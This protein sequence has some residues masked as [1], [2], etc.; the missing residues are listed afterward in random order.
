MN[1]KTPVS[2]I[3]TLNSLINEAHGCAVP[4]TR[5]HFIDQQDSC[6]RY[7]VT[8]AD[9]EVTI[10]VPLPRFS[11]I[12]HLD[13]L[14]E[15]FTPEM[16]FER[17]EAYITNYQ[18]RPTEAISYALATF[19]SQ[20]ALVRTYLEGRFGPLLSKA[21]KLGVAWWAESIDV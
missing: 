8:L 14:H 13:R 11:V 6:Y 21:R 10:T 5:S 2:R 3:K 7:A 9:F 15:A 19:N 18:P 20:P 16:P 12:L 17:L 4:R 1:Q